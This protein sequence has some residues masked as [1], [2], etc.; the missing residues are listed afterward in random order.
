MATCFEGLS[1]FD[2]AE[3]KLLQALDIEKGHAHGDIG[4]SAHISEEEG[5]EDDT[6]GEYAT[7]AGDA[8]GCSNI[9]STSTLNN[10]G[11]LYSHMG[12]YPEAEAVL[13]RVADV[14]A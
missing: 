12:R 2:K 14:R 5:K 3:E 9:E 1:E 7:V 6:R 10:L 13:Q 8:I 4:M 11:V